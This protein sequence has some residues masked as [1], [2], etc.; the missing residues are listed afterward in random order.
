MIQKLDASPKNTTV[1]TTPSSSSLGGDSTLKSH[2]LFSSLKQKLGEMKDSSLA[3]EIKG[4][5]LFK[6]TRATKLAGKLHLFY[7][8]EGK[9][10]EHEYKQAKCQPKMTPEVFKTYM[11]LFSCESTVVCVLQGCFF[12][13]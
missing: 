11:N 8:H 6:I 2:A 13:F 12:L 4:T 9:V 1:S 10:F 3:D 5:Y 7:K